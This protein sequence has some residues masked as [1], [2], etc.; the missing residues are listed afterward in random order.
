MSLPNGE[1]GEKNL[2]NRIHGVDPSSL[3][4]V[5]YRVPAVLHTAS[6]RSGVGL[7]GRELPCSPSFC[8]GSWAEILFSPWAVGSGVEGH[9]K[10]F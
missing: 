1:E 2:K 9:L 8:L 5:R 6:G 4:W 3:C 7:W 10:G